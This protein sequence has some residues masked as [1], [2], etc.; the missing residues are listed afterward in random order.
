MQPVEGLFASGDFFAT[1][2]V[3]ALIGR[4]FTA[5]DACAGEVGPTVR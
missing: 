4:T 3:P 5:S 2:G 1:L